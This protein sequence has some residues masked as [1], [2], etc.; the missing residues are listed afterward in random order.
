MKACSICGDEIEAHVNPIT[1]EVFWTDGHNAYP[2]TDG[3]CCDV[4]NA[5][6]VI[7]TRI[8]GRGEQQ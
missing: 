7:P 6:I 2:I 3:R 5:N 4:C 1:G 8:L